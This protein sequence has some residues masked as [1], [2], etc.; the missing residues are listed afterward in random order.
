MAEP[1]QPIGALAINVLAKCAAK[2]AVVE[3]LRASGNRAVVP[4]REI[5][6]QTRAYL[7]AHPELHEQALAT[8][9]ELSVRDQQGRL[10]AVLFDDDR[11]GWRRPRRSVSVSDNAKTGTDNIDVLAQPKGDLTVA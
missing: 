5:V 3:Q 1:F 7:A 8:A 11:R 2:K 9:W 6:R 10:N 4:H